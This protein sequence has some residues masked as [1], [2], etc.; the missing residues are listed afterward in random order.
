MTTDV[1]LDIIQRY[2]FP[3]A[4]CIWFMLRL[5]KKL[6]MIDKVNHK[7]VV[8]M[9]VLVRIL[10]DKRALGAIPADFIDDVTGVNEIPLPDSATV[11]PQVKASEDKRKNP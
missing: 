4:M 2:G 5:E 1:I 8:I 7:Q 9:A 3:A 11:E 6:D 10:G